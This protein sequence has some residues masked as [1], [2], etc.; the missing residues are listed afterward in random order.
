[1]KKLVDDYRIG[2]VIDDIENSE[3]VEKAI[4][5]IIENYDTYSSNARTCFLKEFDFAAK[6]K[7]LVSYVKSRCLSD[8]APV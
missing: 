3:E 7:P 4:D 2:V 6:I 1:L 5:T 8:I